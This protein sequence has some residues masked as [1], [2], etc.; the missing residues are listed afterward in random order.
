MIVFQ[1]IIG[2]RWLRWR[3]IM[4]DNWRL[5]LSFR[6]IREFPWHLSDLHVS[7]G[8]L[9]MMREYVYKKT[10]EHLDALKSFEST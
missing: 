7:Q 2:E 8:A 10:E 4:A 6:E 1:V 5:V 9:E 3:P